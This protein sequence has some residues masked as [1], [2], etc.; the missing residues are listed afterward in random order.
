MEAAV[1]TADWL[2]KSSAVPTAN[3]ACGCGAYCSTA[4]I[5]SEWRMLSGTCKWETKEIGK[6]SSGVVESVNLIGIRKRSWGVVCLVLNL[7]GSGKTSAGP[8]VAEWL[9]ESALYL[10]P[11]GLF[12]YR[13]GR[14]DVL[15]SQSG[16]TYGGLTYI[17]GNYIKGDELCDDAGKEENAVGGMAIGG[18]G[19]RGDD[20]A[21]SDWYQQHCIEQDFEKQALEDGSVP[22]SWGVFALVL[23]LLAS[24]RP[25]RAK[26][27]GVLVNSSLFRAT[28]SFCLSSGSRM[29]LSQ[30]GW[31][32]R[33]T[34]IEG[35]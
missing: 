1:T 2:R 3:V 14:Q 22:R 26:R 30:S 8:N 32:W 11:R 9:G 7:L 12:A 13:S 19:M 10:G 24:G 35:N 17:E 31:I 20:V 25:R 16:W 23:N 29:A 28:R 4:N 21:V 15:L 5:L 34:Y 27:S 33:T 18:L 6:W